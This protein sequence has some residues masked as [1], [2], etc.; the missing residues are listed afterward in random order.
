MK[1]ETLE[2]IIKALEYKKK[3]KEDWIERGSTMAGSK[4]KERARM[5]IEKIDKALEDLNENGKF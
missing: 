3:R 1:K 4:T 5:E 2:T